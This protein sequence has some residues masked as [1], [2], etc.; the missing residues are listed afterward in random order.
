MEDIQRLTV[1]EAIAT[2][3]LLWRT[4]RDWLPGFEDWKLALALSIAVGYGRQCA[5]NRRELDALIAETAAASAT[6]AARDAALDIAALI[7]S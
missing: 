1:N 5:A 2:Y 3:P 6:G 7:R 4:F